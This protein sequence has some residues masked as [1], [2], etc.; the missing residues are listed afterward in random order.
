MHWKKK[1]KKKHEMIFFSFFIS[2]IVKKYFKTNSGLGS[3]SAFKKKY[4]FFF[5]F[6]FTISLTKQ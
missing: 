4:I 3:F 2:S 5:T 6:P 1:K